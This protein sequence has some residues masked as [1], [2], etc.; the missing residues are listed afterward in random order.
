VDTFTYV[1]S[2]GQ[3][4]TD[5][6]TVT[7]NVT[8]VNDAPT[9]PDRAVTTPEDVPYGF[10]AA[11]FAGLV[12]A[13]GDSLQ[14]IRIDAPPARGV[15]LLGGAP[16]GAGDV[17]PVDQLGLLTWVPPPNEN[18][19]DFTSFRVSAYDG[20]AFA[21]ASTTVTV[22]VT[23][24]NDP[25]VGQNQAVTTPEDTPIS[26]AVSATDPDAGDSLTF[27]LLGGPAFGRVAVS[28]DGSYT[29]TPD[30]DYNG[31]DRFTVRVADGKG[32][33]DTIV[34]DVTVT[35]V[36]D[37]PTLGGDLTD[38]VTEDVTLA[39]TGQVTSDDVD[40]GEALV[41]PAAVDGIYGRFAVLA[42]G[43][44]TYSLDNADP[45]VQALKAGETR[46]EVF[47][48]TS[49]DG[50]AGATVTVTLVGT[51]DPPVAR[52]DDAT[53]AEDT[54]LVIGAG[55]LLAD[56]SDL[57]GDPLRVV[58]V[59]P[60]SANGGRLALNADGT[61]TYVPAANF[62]GVDT[63]SYTI[64][65]GNGGFATTTV[66]VTVTPV[67]DP[68]V[69]APDDG[70]VS[71]EGQGKTYAPAQLTGNDSDVDG[72]PLTIAAVSPTSANGGTVTLGADGTVT[73]VPRPGF[74]GIDTFTYTLSDG[75]GGFSTAT[76]TVTVQADPYVPPSSSTD[77][78]DAEPFVIDQLR[79][80]Y[81]DFLQPFDPALFVLPAVK[82]AFAIGSQAI[83]A[84]TNLGISYAGELGS[85][86]LARYESLTPGQIVMRQGVADARELAQHAAARSGALLN[87]ILPG[88]QTLF[89]DLSPFGPN[90]ATGEEVESAP[91]EPPAEPAPS[92]PRQT[93]AP[94]G[95][96]GFSEQLR[97]AAQA[98][99][100][101]VA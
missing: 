80:G 74:S 54:P 48:V 12:D 35:P 77:A 66:T 41:I 8:P 53:T 21:A 17:I 5:T 69:A 85:T 95:A 57:D 62:N 22:N 81:P 26:G 65:D 14:A 63:F 84:M 6:V 79:L 20:V 43:T 82:E 23:P 44:W 88:A 56:D 93:E 47:T 70:G 90:P 31:P 15:L 16:V 92:G 51:N 18:G 3:G 28:T 58:A 37:V 97:A 59:S 9:L 32:G 29:Y 52:P 27:S 86:L 40:P 71:R 83:D 19:A 96:K 73:Y 1:V 94:R 98:K 25:P 50:T 100:Q 4:G 33:I 11:D 55:A 99:F 72:D 45:A 68:P 61:V 101:R 49:L 10:T 36:N 76:V 89:D 39:A 38:T 24:V 91:A 34:V 87:T 67:N 13:D 42:D 75:R 64:G 30:P 7:I 2:D 46:T 60:T 78:G